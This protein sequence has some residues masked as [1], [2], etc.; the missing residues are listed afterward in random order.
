MLL[1]REAANGRLHLLHNTSQHKLLPSSN[2]QST[3]THTKQHEQAAAIP[4]TQAK[5]AGNSSAK[6]K[7]ADTT[8]HKRETHNLHKKIS[9]NTIQATSFNNSLTAS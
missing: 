8:K 1:Q 3:K 4:R 2:L 7:P 5:H 6:R 9:A